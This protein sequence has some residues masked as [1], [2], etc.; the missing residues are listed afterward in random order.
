M[1]KNITI[2][3]DLIVNKLTTKPPSHHEPYMF[4]NT[5]MLLEYNLY[6]DQF[7]MVGRFLTK[8]YT[9]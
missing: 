5:Y 9:F 2:K 3:A 4:C 1:A 7:K 8:Q 6:L